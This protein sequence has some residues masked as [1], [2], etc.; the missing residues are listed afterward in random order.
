MS[1][2]R[3]CRLPILT[4]DGDIDVGVD[5]PVAVCDCQSVGGAV[6]TLCAVTHQLTGVLQH[7]NT[8]PQILVHDTQLQLN[9]QRSIFNEG[10]TEPPP[11]A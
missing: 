6:S 1:S 11:R 10:K 9:I 2:D 8:V 5:A 7:F 4:D 3:E